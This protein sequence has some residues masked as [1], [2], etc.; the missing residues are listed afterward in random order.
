MNGSAFTTCRE[1]KEW[2]PTVGKCVYDPQSEQNLSFRNFL[3]CKKSTCFAMGLHV[4]IAVFLD[5]PNQSIKN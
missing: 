4:A 2:Y 5:T 1:N 3:I